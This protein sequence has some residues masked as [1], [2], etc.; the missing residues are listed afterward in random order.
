SAGTYNANLALSMV[1]GG[2]ATPYKSQDQAIKVQSASQINAQTISLIQGLSLSTP[3]QLAQR[4]AIVDLLNQ[5]NTA[6]SS[7]SMDKALR[8]LITVQAKLK[9]IETGVGPASKSLANLIAVV[10]R[11]SAR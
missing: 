6:M 2:T 8:L 3:A 1:S 4:T 5:V 10:E 9:N 7:N 11:Q